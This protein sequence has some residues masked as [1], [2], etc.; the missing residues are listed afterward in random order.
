[1]TESEIGD[2]ITGFAQSAANAKA[3]GFDGI[4]IHGALDLTRDRAG[5]ERAQG[6]KATLDA[7]VAALQ[8][9]DLPEAV[10]EATEAPKTVKN[11]FA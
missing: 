11:P 7:I 5:L 9:Q 4:A 2:V 3:V 1:M 8:A 6:L 10:A